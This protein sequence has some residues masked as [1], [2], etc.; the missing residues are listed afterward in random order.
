MGMLTRGFCW[1]LLCL[2]KNDQGDRRADFSLILVKDFSRG[3]D[4]ETE[5]IQV[6]PE[7]LNL[8]ENHI[9]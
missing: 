5:V 3:R 4:G 1:K 8:C 9:D 6:R 2:G 7:I